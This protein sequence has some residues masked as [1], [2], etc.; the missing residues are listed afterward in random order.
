MK[1]KLIQ[2]LR[3]V[4]VILFITIRRG[5]PYIIHYVSLRLRKQPIEAFFRF[6]FL[7]SN[8]R[9]VEIGGPS[10]IFLPKGIFPVISVSKEVDNVNYREKTIWGET[11]SHFYR[12][13]IICEAASLKPIKDKEYD[14][15]ITSNVIEHLAN[16]LKAF[17]EW[18]RIIKSGG[19]MLIVFPNKDLTFDHRRRPTTI[20]H[21]IDDFKNNVDEQDLSHLIEIIEL[22]DITLDPYAGTFKDFIIR[23]LK[24]YEYRCL[25]HH[26][27][28]LSSLIK[29]LKEF[30]GMEIIYANEI[31]LNNLIIIARRID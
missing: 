27:F 3:T 7:F 9:G 30:L 28:T 10:K 19:I 15:L 24:N 21:I 20:D 17:L 11:N 16:P 23:S 18:K 25:H 13:T 5:L 12:K 22:H 26:V 6:S 14:F 2:Y 4:K 8:K 1:R 31:P 29:L